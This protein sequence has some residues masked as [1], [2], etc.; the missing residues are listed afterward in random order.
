MITPLMAACLRGRGG[1]GGC[2][3]AAARGDMYVAVAKAS[4]VGCW[5]TSLAAFSSCCLAFP[6]FRF[7]SSF[8]AL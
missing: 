8:I 6:F 4:D 1:C 2:W 3:S 7:S 5:T